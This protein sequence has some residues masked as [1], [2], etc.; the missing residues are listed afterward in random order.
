MLDFPLIWWNQENVTM[1]EKSLHSL[2]LMVLTAAH[3]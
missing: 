2:L 3:S 1:W